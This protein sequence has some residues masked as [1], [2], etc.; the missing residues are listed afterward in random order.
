MHRRPEGCDTRVAGR[1]P[2][3][4][5]VALVGA[6][7]RVEHDDPVVAIAVGDEQLVR[8]GIDGHR[9]GPVEMPGVRV[10]ADDPLPADLQEELAVGREL[11]NLAVLRIVARDP[12]VPLRVD[13]DAVLVERPVVARARPA[14]G[15]DQDAGAVE[16]EDR[17]GRDTA[18]RARRHQRGAPLGL[19]QAPRPVDH[20]HVIL[21]VDGDARGLPHQPVVGERLGPERVDLEPRQSPLTLALLGQDE[22]GQR[23]RDE[24]ESGGQREAPGSASR[25][26][27]PRPACGVRRRNRAAPG[28]GGR[29]FASGHARP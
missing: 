10:P 11:E 26:P 17:R 27:L 29:G 19:G 15:A 23:E 6:S 8:L 25:P 22:A 4:A 24:G 20:P 28:Q 16:L 14:P 2:V 18:F 21:G 1:A 5:P 3:G 7:L 12:H 9:R 13:E